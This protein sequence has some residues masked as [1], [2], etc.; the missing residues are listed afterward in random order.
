MQ[1][2]TFERGRGVAGVAGLG[3]LSADYEIPVDAL[4][5][6]GPLELAAGSGPIVARAER[7]RT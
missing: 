4:V 2:A 1:H 5:A 3:Q 7:C 6:F